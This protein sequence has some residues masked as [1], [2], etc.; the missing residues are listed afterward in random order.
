MLWTPDEVKS[1]EGRQNCNFLHPYTC[2]SGCGA[3]IPTEDGW[4]CPKCEY[5]Q[6]WAHAND[7]NGEWEKLSPI[8]RY[9]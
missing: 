9:A 1:L 3:L 8:F 4:V 2:D 7:L 5:T 6:D